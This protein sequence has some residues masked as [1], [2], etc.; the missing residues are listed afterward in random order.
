VG[1]T[2][3]HT[4][5]KGAWI[6]THIFLNSTLAFFTTPRLTS[7]K[8]HFISAPEEVFRVKNVLISDLCQLQ[9]I[10]TSLRI[11]GVFGDLLAFLLSQIKGSRHG[12]MSGL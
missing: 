5:S 3:S 11:Y 4:G 8:W 2:D 1:L 7:L 10:A 6:Q 12:K 9:T